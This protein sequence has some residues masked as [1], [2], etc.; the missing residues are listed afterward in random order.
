MLALN[1][2]HRAT[3]ASVELRV[4]EV[5]FTTNAPRLLEPITA[6]QF[7][8]TGVSRLEV[9]GA[10]FEITVRSGTEKHIVTEGFA[11]DGDDASSC[12]FYSVRASPLHLDEASTITLTWQDSGRAFGI[13]SQRPLSGVLSF[14][15]SGGAPGFTCTGMNV[16]GTRVGVEARVHDSGATAYYSTAPDTRVDLR[17]PSSNARDTQIEVLEPIV[18]SQVTPGSKPQEKTVLL[19]G[20][21]LRPNQIVF[22]DPKQTI[23][24]DDD[25]IVRITPAHDFY[26][27]SFLIA[28][29]INLDFHG[30]LRDVSIG[31]GP[32]DLRSCM[33][34]LF[35]Q[36]T[37]RNKLLGII[38]S[39]AALLLGLLEKMGV[40]RK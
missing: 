33:P 15:A 37:A 3:A 38:P 19:R 21:K 9:Q 16:N 12:A 2:V 35:E 27:R 29:G 17:D 13:G 40:I 28:E 11:V 8:I 10:R 31:A 26:L 7:L 24:V 5:S 18:F 1:H 34:S 23:Q 36:L 39:I 30:W 22:D 20:S 6:K 25:D 14:E 32:G 4:R